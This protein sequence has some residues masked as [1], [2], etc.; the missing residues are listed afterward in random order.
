MEKERTLQILKEAYQMEI[1]GAFY[2]D[3][4]AR[5]AKTTEAKESF[6]ALVEEEVKHQEFLIEQI[7]AITEHG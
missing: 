2:Y 6:F 3:L 5:N 4:L 7:H 1:E